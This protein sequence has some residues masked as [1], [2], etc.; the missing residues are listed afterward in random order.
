MKYYIDIT[1]IP[2]PEAS[3]YFLWQKVYQQI[4]FA[5]VEVQEKGKVN[6][7]VAFPE[8]DN[9]K[10]HLGNRLRLFAEKKRYLMRLNLDFFLDG[11]TDYIQISETK[12]VP[13][14]ITGHVFFKRV[15]TKSNNERLA[16]RRAK[17][18]GISYLQALADLN[19]REET[20]IKTPFIQMKSHSSGQTYRLMISRQQTDIVPTT[21]EFST[22]GLS[23]IT[24]VPI[25]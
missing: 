10:L 1:L 18:K 7:G 3:L 23:N 9:H 6:V 16:R 13:E 25:F 4:H 19:E 11:L 17:R 5:L 2:Y 24:P 20:F 15:Q 12:H 8:Y 14:K 22:Y 21:Y